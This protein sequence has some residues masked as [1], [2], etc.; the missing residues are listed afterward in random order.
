MKPGATALTVMPFA[1]Q[2]ASHR[3][4][5]ADQAGFRGHVVGLAEV[6]VEPYYRRGIDDASVAGFKHVVQYG[7]AAVE[8][9]RKI[10][11]DHVLPLF[12]GHF[13]ERA[14]VGDAGIVDQDVD[15]A[16]LV[17]DALGR[18]GYRLE[19][20]RIDL[21]EGDGEPFGCGFFSPFPYRGLRYVPIRLPVRLRVRNAVP[22]LRRYRPCR[23]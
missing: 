20:A 3:F 12:D 15:L 1:S 6:A 21:V 23:P 7:L 9:A 18:S 2:F 4:G 5:H 19:I 8:R 14:V 22:L 13:L 17:G 16:E 11:V 10:D